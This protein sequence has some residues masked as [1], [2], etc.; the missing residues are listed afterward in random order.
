[1]RRVTPIHT[2]SYRHLYILN[3]FVYTGINLRTFPVIWLCSFHENLLFR[4]SAT[5]GHL[6]LRLTNTFSCGRRVRTRA[7][8]IPAW[9]AAEQ[10]ILHLNLLIA[11]QWLSSSSFSPR[12]T[13]SRRNAERVNRA[14]EFSYVTARSGHDFRLESRRIAERE[15]GEDGTLRWSPHEIAR[16]TT[17]ALNYG[18]A[19]RRIAENRVKSS[20]DP[21]HGCWMPRISSSRSLTRRERRRRFGCMD[22]AEV[23]RRAVKSAKLWAYKPI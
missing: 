2:H 18:A 7:C 6:P 9:K 8:V 11:L 22:L 20:R 5:L 3:L 13:E 21:W 12:I 19:V 16:A 10:H 23:N 15:R 14:V 1:M 4:L 17:A